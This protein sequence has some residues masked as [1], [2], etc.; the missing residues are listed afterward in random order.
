LVVF[1]RTFVLRKKTGEILGK[2]ERGVF[3]KENGEIFWEERER[4]YEQILGDFIL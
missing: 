2:N 4:V 3:G 1:G